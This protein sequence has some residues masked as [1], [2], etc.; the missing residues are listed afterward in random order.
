MLELEKQYMFERLQASKPRPPNPL[1]PRHL[2]SVSP[3]RSS[4]QSRRAPKAAV[5]PRNPSPAERVIP[6]VINT[7]AT[8]ARPKAKP[9]APAD[10]RRETP[11]KDEAAPDCQREAPAMDAPPTAVATPVDK[12][13]SKVV[14]FQFPPKEIDQRSICV[15]PSWETHGRRKKEKMEKG[16]RDEAAKNCEGL[17]KKGRLS[18]QPPPASSTEA[19]KKVEGFAPDSTASRSRQKERLSSPRQEAAPRKP[20]SRSSSF[21]SLIRSPFEFRRSSVDQPPEPEFIGGIKLEQERHLAHERALNEQAKA[22][23]ANIHPA[24]RDNK[25]SNR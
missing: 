25:A 9:E 8:K 5:G 10:R 7:S 13:G 23:E 20:R 12:P 16:E 24:L 21:A 1:P 4:I 3:P 6:L 17:A 19:L 14:S 11:V 2:A 15:S 22:D 18:K